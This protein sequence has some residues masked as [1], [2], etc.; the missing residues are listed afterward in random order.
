[1][2]TTFGDGATYGPFAVTGH[3]ALAF[4]FLWP[5]VLLLCDVG[6]SKSRTRRSFGEEQVRASDLKSN[7][8]MLVGAAWAVGALLAVLRFGG[9]GGQ[10]GPHTWSRESARFVLLSLVFCIAFIMPTPE[11]D[12]RSYTS[13]VTRSVQKAI[14]AYA[15]GLFVAGVLFAWVRD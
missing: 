2:C 9:G 15:I 7:S 11:D 1:M 3:P 8:N 5:M 14:L 6:A 10:K 12:L 13:V 4:A